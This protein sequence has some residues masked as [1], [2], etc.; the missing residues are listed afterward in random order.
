M[1]FLYIHSIPFSFRSLVYLNK[2]YCRNKSII[3]MKLLI[4]KSAALHAFPQSQT[5]TTYPPPR[6]RPPQGGPL[7]HSKPRTAQTSLG[8]TVAK[9]AGVRADAAADGRILRKIPNRTIRTQLA[10]QSDLPTAYKYPSRHS[11]GTIYFLRGSRL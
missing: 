7:L 8:R 11:D 10:S 9:G 4:S 3:Q 1:I 5:L 2:I 6:Y